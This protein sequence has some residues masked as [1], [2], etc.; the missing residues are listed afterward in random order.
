M[1]QRRVS[2][3]R[4][5]ANQQRALLALTFGA[6]ALYLALS[7]A[8]SLAHALAGRAG[9]A[10]LALSLVVGVA[11]VGFVLWRRLQRAAGRWRQSAWLTQADTLAALRA[12]TPTQFELAIGGLMRRSGYSDVR[13]TGG[14]GD[15]AADLIC[16][17]GRGARVVVQ[18]KRYGAGCAV[19]SP[20][21]QQ[22]I[23][24]IYA[25]HHAD[26]G[27]YVTT[28]TFTQPASA[29]AAQHR[30]RLLDGA[31]LAARISLIS[32]SH[33]PRR[34]RLADMTLEGVVEGGLRLKPHL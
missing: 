19:T 29:L 12:L 10:W 24:M 8:Q 25:H 7:A 14:G 6:L 22:F 1:A 28:S 2:R 11:L 31:H 4:R 17:D 15:L 21:M 3:R 26:Y 13:H 9:Q 27:V 16:R 5:S 23:G 33:A 32:A 30:I 34:R 20:E 18:C